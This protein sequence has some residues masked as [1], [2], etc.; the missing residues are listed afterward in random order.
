MRLSIQLLILGLMSILVASLGNT[1]F[2][3]IFPAAAPAPRL[4]YLKQRARTRR[5]PL[6]LERRMRRRSAARRRVVMVCAIAMKAAGAN[7]QGTT[8]HARD[9]KDRMGMN[10]TK[11]HPKRKFRSCCCAANSIFQEKQKQDATRCANYNLM[12]Y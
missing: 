4:M 1:R 6:A 2:F 12:L 7:L 9:E 8:L 5:V 11:G 10:Q 3:L